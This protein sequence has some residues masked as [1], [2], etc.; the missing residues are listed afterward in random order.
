[1][2]TENFNNN[3]FKEQLV[4]AVSAKMKQELGRMPMKLPNE[5]GDI[6]EGYLSY[7]FKFYNFIFSSILYSLLSLLT[8]IWKKDKSYQPITLGAKSWSLLG[9]FLY[10]NG[11]WYWFWHKKAPSL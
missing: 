7:F 11:L 6:T 2:D 8:V 5:G 9:A 10:E 4:K 1:M 3:K